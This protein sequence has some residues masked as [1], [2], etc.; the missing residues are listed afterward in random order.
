MSINVAPI[1]QHNK[2]AIKSCRAAC[3]L[4]P[5]LV[6]YPRNGTSN[7]KNIAHGLSHSEICAILVYEAMQK[8]HEISGENLGNN[9]ESLRNYLS[10]IAVICMS[11]ESYFSNPSVVA[12]K[13]QKAY[14]LCV[15]ILEHNTNT[16]GIDFLNLQKATISISRALGTLGI[17]C[18]DL[19]IP[20]TALGACVYVPPFP[21]ETKLENSQALSFNVEND[22]IQKTQRHSGNFIFVA[23]QKILLI[24]SSAIKPIPY[25][26]A[27]LPCPHTPMHAADEITVLFYRCIYIHE[28]TPYGLFPFFEKNLHPTHSQKG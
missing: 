21:G 14:K 17:S 22:G 4:L 11:N 8:I 9:L 15:E 23:I 25:F 13:L 26:L 18:K 20:S 10:D 12:H 7:P 16:E 27:H 28:N 2:A 3:Y 5:N 24:T 19:P 1:R 6:P